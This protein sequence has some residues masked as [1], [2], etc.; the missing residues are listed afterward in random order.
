M[1]TDAVSP[2]AQTHPRSK[3]DATPSVEAT[4]TLQTIVDNQDLFDRVLVHVAPHEL[5]HLLV[6]RSFHAAADSELYWRSWLQKELA[7]AVQRAPPCATH[8][9]RINGDWSVQRGGRQPTDPEA[10]FVFKP[11]LAVARC[12][13]C[14]PASWRSAGAGQ[15]AGPP[16][17]EHFKQLLILRHIVAAPGTRRIGWGDESDAEWQPL[18]LPWNPAAELTPHGLLAAL[19]AHAQLQQDGACRRVDSV[20]DEDEDD[21]SRAY[22]RMSVGANEMVRWRELSDGAAP[23]WRL[24]PSFRTALRYFLSQHPKTAVF[25]AGSARLNPVPCFAVARV[26][27]D[28][29][30][31]FVGGVVHT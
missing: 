21:E 15:G 6:S 20:I 27:P 5:V 17:R 2:A 12:G 8:E 31:G 28:L 23:R 10:N 4:P 1:T 19:G 25:H 18:I 3:P 13:V 30:A 22:Y 14:R 7:P 16:S 11:A 26:R 9:W 24:A 29:V